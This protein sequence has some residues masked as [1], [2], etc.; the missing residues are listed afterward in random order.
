MILVF[1]IMA[2]VSGCA[3]ESY[4]ASGLWGRARRADTA[5]YEN[6]IMA[7]IYVQKERYADAVRLQ[8]RALEKDPDSIVIRTRLAGTLMLAGE[9]ASA[10]KMI[11]DVL[12]CAPEYAD[13]WTVYGRVLESRGE[14]S[15]AAAAFSRA[16]ALSVRPVN[17]EPFLALASIRLESGDI[18]GAV[19]AYEELA[20][21]TS[22]SLEMS[23]SLTLWAAQSTCPLSALEL[24]RAKRMPFDAAV[25]SWKV[26]DRACGMLEKKETGRAVALLRA[27]AAARPQDADILEALFCL[28]AA[29]GDKSAA[30]LMLEQ[31]KHA[32]SVVD[33][34]EMARL[35]RM[36]GMHSEAVSILERLLKESPESG[37]V[38]HE[39]YLL[40]PLTAGRA[41]GMQEAGAEALEEKARSLVCSKGRS[42]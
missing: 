41:A 19:S 20:I 26:M 16:V 23:G 33:E 25:F 38:W 18:D 24:L 7:E 42:L 39:L 5:A 9:E 1:V 31:L 8:N 27:A 21:G 10:Q 6:F 12:D 40:E 11:L 22:T 29:I 32:E 2:T 34:L 37:E 28:Y 35:E 3:R 14:V 13:A 36:A 17:P 4:T 15:D 30:G